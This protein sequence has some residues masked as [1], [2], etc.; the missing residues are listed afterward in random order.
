MNPIK[1][2][3]SVT[4]RRRCFY[5]IR[6]SDD[7]IEYLAKI[8]DAL[9]AH[10][11]NVRW[12]PRRNIHLTL[13]FLGE[14]DD[15][16]FQTARTFAPVLPEQPIRLRA[17][18]L[19]AFPSLRSARVIWAGV[20]TETED[21]E[22]GLTRLQE[23]TERHAQS[24]GLAREQRPWR[25]HITLARVPYPSPG[26]RPLIDDITTRECRS[27]LC[28]VN[29]LLLMESIMSPHGVEYTTVERWSR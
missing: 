16:Q 8:T 9:R 7:V 1:S 28:A 24:I 19:G 4:L 15:R 3:Q 6:F 13:R 12:A 10:G 22:I 11:A 14:L 26:L 18:G 25:P 5:A 23:S 27:P 29:D 20:S 21:D 2:S 17:D